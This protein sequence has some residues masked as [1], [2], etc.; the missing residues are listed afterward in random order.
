ML[1]R[2][3]GSISALIP[4]PDVMGQ[5]ASRLSLSR[6]IT[7]TTSS[8]LSVPAPRSESLQYEYRHN[9]PDAHQIRPGSLHYEI[10]NPKTLD[11]A[12]QHTERSQSRS[13]AS[14]RYK[15]QEHMSSSD[16]VAVYSEGLGLHCFYLKVGPRTRGHRSIVFTPVHSFYL[17]KR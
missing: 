1:F 2:S 13:S 16:H 5:S 14:Q 8:R 10:S 11:F 7:T 9:F 4:P 12:A 17:F 6:A 3:A 15:P